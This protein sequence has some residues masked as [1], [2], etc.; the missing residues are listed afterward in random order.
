MFILQKAIRMA[1]GHDNC[2]KR[3]K[4]KI[5]LFFKMQEKCKAWQR[6][7]K[8]QMGEKAEEKRGQ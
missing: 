2:P 7:Q 4:S 3:R 5:F 6:Q 1:D 8:S